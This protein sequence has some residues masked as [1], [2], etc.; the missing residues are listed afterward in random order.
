MRSDKLT[1]VIQAVPALFAACLLAVSLPFVNSGCA[2]R[3]VQEGHSAFVVEVESDLKAAHHLVNA[4]LAWEWQN[5]A[6]LG[7]DVVEAA[8]VL[9]LNFGPAYDSATRVLRTYKSSRTPQN[10]ADLNTAL[11]VLNQMLAEATAYMPAQIRKV[12]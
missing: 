2:S 10:K 11:A 9:R 1:G 5:R 7:S 6:V 4:F 3:Q 12:E 8:E